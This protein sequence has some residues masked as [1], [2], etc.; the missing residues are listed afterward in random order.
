MQEDASEGIIK[1]VNIQE[2][3]YYLSKERWD[4]LHRDGDID[5]IFNM[6]MEHFMFHLDIACPF[7]EYKVKWQPQR[8]TWLTRGILIS[9]E[10]LKLYYS[11][12]KTSNNE[13]FKIFFQNY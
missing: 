3:N 4:F 5:I 7:T 8:N 10:K 12:F 1:P 9:Q 2:L 6:F 11:I 13:Q